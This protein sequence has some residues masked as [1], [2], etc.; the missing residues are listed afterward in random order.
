VVSK[1]TSSQL[2]PILSSASQERATPGQMTAAP[3][4]VVQPIVRWITAHTQLVWGTARQALVID[5]WGGGL[6]GDEYRQASQAGGLAAVPPGDPSSPHAANPT[7]L[8]Q[9]PKN[10]P[11]IRAARIMGRTLVVIWKGCLASGLDRD[12][13]CNSRIDSEAT[14]QCLRT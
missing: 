14:S 2:R 5:C 1:E 11:M 4:R 6:G 10:Q 3:R 7:L 12:D 13:G 8:A 9:A